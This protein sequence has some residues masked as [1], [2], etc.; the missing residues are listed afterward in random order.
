[1]DYLAIAYSLIAVV[2]AGYTISLWRR[3]QASRRERE[4]LETKND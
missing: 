3:M 2:L 4:R 1:M